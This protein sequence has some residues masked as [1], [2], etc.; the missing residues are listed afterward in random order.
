MSASEEHHGTFLR[1]YSMLTHM[2][3]TPSKYSPTLGA[4]SQCI[5]YLLFVPPAHAPPSAI[6]QP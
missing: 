3:T 5:M 2:H 4:S 6:T 1:R